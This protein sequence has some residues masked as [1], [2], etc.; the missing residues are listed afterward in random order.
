MS[1]I[2]NVL[3]VPHS[4]GY[5]VFC[6]Q[7][8]CIESIIFKKNESGDEVMGS[9][10]EFIHLTRVTEKE[11]MYIY[12]VMVSGC[13][14]GILCH[15]SNSENSISEV[16]NIIEEPLLHCTLPW[17]K[18]DGMCALKEII[19]GTNCDYTTADISNLLH[20]NGVHSDISI[21][22]SEYTYRISKNIE[23]HIEPQ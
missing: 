9:T 11:S 5:G 19:I 16:S 2:E 21:M 23:F 22:K 6:A 4:R 18:S 15:G 17:L 1:D 3:P 7:I 10:Q 12:A 20:K 13:M 8:R 14:L